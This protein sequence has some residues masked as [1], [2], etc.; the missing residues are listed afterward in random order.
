MK[1]SEWKKI[2]DEQRAIMS[3]LLDKLLQVNDSYA[4]V[5]EQY[6]D[7]LIEMAELRE[8]NDNMIARIAELEKD[9]ADMSVVVLNSTQDMINIDRGSRE[10]E[11]LLIKKTERIEFLEVALRQCGETIDNMRGLIKRH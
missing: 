4:Q 7:A 1:K 6:T 8:A 5:R 9:L 3:D 2:C 10:L 11:R